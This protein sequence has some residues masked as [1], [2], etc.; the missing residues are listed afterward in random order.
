MSRQAN[1][2]NEGDTLAWKNQ[3]GGTLTC[4]NVVIVGKIIAILMSGVNTEDTTLADTLTG[5][6]AVRGVWELP[7]YSA[8]TWVEGASLFWDAGNSRLTTTATGNV[9]AGRAT[10]IGAASATRA[11]VDLNE[12]SSADFVTIDEDQTLAEGKDIS[13]GTVTGTKIGTATAQKIGF[14]NA[15]PIIQPAAAAQAALTDNSGGTAAPT[16]GVSANANKETIIIPIQLL[17]LVDTAV[18]KIALPF[19][20]TLLSA[21]FRTGKVV[22]TGSKLSTLTTKVSGGAV[23]GGVMALTSANQNTTG[24][25]VAATAISGAGATGAAGGTLEVAV[26]STTAF[27]EGDGYVEFTVLNL[28][29]A[30]QAAT[31]AA[32]TNA[33]RTALVNSGL[34]KGAA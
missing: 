34:I 7:K 21:L 22:S 30:H 17:G 3:T 16:A 6:V 26:S 18:H 14:W 19:A 27:V 13:T 9:Y 24:G 5:M 31:I 20:F 8:D 33:F 1:K 25:T 10:G 4:G 11:T 12:L 15:T 2:V 29:K 28:D 23:T 32:Q